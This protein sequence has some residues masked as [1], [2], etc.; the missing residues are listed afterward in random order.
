MTR[1]RP[2]DPNEQLYDPTKDPSLKDIINDVGV[3]RYFRLIEVQERPAISGSFGRCYSPP[4]AFRGDW[5]S[6][7]WNRNPAETT[8]GCGPPARARQADIGDWLQFRR[9]SRFGARCQPRTPG[10]KVTAA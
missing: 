8:S 4:T 5:M 10:F 2:R 3:V 9:S 7:R 6:V 1:R